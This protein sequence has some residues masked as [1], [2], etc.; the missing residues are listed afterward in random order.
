MR[1]RPRLT[2]TAELVPSDL[3]VADIGSDHAYLP[4]HLVRQGIAPRAIA[5]DIET[6]PLQNAARAVGQAGLQDKIELRQS[7]G[8][9]RFAAH[10]AQCWVLAGMGGTLM[11]RL[12]DAAPWLQQPGT[13]IVAQ[14]MR[15]AHELRA[16]LVAHGFA[17]EQERLCRDAGRLYIALR[18]VHDGQPRVCP[19]GYAYYGELLHN[20]E[21]LAQEY[22]SREAKYVRVRMEALRAS[23]QNNNELALLE[24]V[25]HDFCARNL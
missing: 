11:V 5:A 15:R 13:V 10:E 19:P 23:G 2:M 14:P 6:G 17:I 16:W 3:V 22:L 18:A 24:E 9:S 4:V 7:D 12:L 1:L 21:P 8:F 25:T 20:N